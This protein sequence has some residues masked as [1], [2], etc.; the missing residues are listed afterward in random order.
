MLPDPRV[1]VVIPAYNHGAWIEETLEA[2]VRQTFTEWEAIVVDDGSTDDTGE[3]ARRFAPRVRYVRQEN[4][5]VSAARNNGLAKT[6]GRYVTFLD[7]DDLFRPN[8]LEVLVAALDRDPSLGMVY[9]SQCRLKDG[10]VFD[11]STPCHRGDILLPLLLKDQSFRLSSGTTLIRRDVLQAVQAFD[12]R[13]STSAD[14][15]LWL[16]LAASYPV[17]FVPEPVLDYRVTP[18]AMHRNLRLF[19]RD[20]LGVL[21]KFYSKGAGRRPE[22]A[23][24]RSCAYARAHYCIGGEALYQRDWSLAFRHLARVVRLDPLFAARRL[25]GWP[26]RRAARML[27]KAPHPGE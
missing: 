17:D 7:S 21:D 13:F 9:G 6:T 2:V 4:A 11:C 12:P 15:D 23:A 5:G 20:R 16:R 24:L 18:G 8:G 27:G 26:G 25:G 19:E 10:L 14:Y 3:V 1:S 22:L